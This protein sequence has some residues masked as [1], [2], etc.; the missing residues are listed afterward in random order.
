M[1]LCMYLFIYWLSNMLLQN[2][3]PKKVKLS[4]TRGLQIII[5]ETGEIFTLF[6]LLRQYLDSAFKSLELKLNLDFW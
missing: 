4:H 5:Q 2:A 3:D 6:I 1:K